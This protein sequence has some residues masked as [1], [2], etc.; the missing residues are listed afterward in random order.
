[1]D[2][3]PQISSAKLKFYTI[4]YWQIFMLKLSRLA[5]LLVQL[6]FNKVVFNEKY[7]TF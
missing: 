3:A 5:Y 4:E 2:L 7:L 6:L 1:M